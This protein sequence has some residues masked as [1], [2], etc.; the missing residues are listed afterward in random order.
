MKN[1]KTDDHISNIIYQFTRQAL[2]FSRQPA[3]SQEAFM[4]LL[5]EMSGVGHQDTVLDV[6]CGPGLVAAAFAAHAQHVTGIDLTPAMIARA[7]QIQQ[8]RGLTNLTWQIGTVLPLPYR[9]AAFSL[10]ITRYSFHHFLEP[11]AVFAEMVRVCAP[12]GTVMVADLTMALEKREFFDAA[13]RLRDPSH[14]RTLTPDELG[15]MAAALPLKAIRTRFYRTERNLNA[16]LKASFPRPGDEEKIRQI[17]R[18][19]IGHDRLGLEARW[20]GDEIYFSYP[21]IVM[22]GR[23]A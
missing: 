2:P 19:D 11:Q 18:E 21:I 6:A 20:Q 7:Q 3:H 15:R 17:F 16:H 5:L 8:E 12:G 22:A 13:E 23:K 4:N 9:D 1:N 14:T 10:V